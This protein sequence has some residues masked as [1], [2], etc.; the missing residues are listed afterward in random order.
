MGGDTQLLEEGKALF[1]AH[2][3]ELTDQGRVRATRL[4]VRIVTAMAIQLLLS[5]SEHPVDDG[6]FKERVAN[7]RFVMLWGNGRFSRKCEGEGECVC[8]CVCVCAMW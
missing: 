2:L 8:V 7:V 5:T 1:S 4:A 3:T 6:A